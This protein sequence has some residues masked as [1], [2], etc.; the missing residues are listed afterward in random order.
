[1]VRPILVLAFALVFT[2]I[3]SLD[4]PDSSVMKVTQQR[5]IDLRNAMA[6]PAVR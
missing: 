6:A 2:V 3:D 1:L 4:R 5:L